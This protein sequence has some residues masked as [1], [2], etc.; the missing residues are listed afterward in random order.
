MHCASEGMLTP[1][2]LRKLHRCLAWN[3]PDG[4]RKGGHI[5]AD[6]CRDVKPQLD[7][8]CFVVYKG[9]PGRSS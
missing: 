1:I 5:I 6:A 9:I 7:D 2:D 4:G 3:L 8:A